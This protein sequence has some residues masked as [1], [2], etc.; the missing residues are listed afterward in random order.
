MNRRIALGIAVLILIGLG[1]WLWSRPKSKTTEVNTD[2]NQT[3]SETPEPILSVRAFNQTVNTEAGAAPAHQGDILAFTLTAENPASQ[4]IPGYVVKVN[5]SDLVASATLVD[6]GGAAYNSSDRALSWTP[7]DIPAGQS[8][9]QRFT[10]RVNQ[11]LKNAPDSVI[12]I[13]F[14]NDIQ[15]GITG[16]VAGAATAQPSG[17]TGYRAP[18]SGTNEN[19]I[20]LLALFATIIWF[21]RKKLGITHDKI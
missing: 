15:I 3:Q 17:Q 4:P 16:R 21:G 10:A 2:T 12:K 18:V 8:I 19:I 9:Q 7:L 11:L 13:S 5:I 14:N 1:I 20:V 6:S